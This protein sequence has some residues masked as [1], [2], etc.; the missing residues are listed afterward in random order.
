M[1]ESGPGGS[2]GA[3]W[4]AGRM[5]AIIKIGKPFPGGGTTNLN[6]KETAEMELKEILGKCDHTLLAQGATREEI[7]AICDDGIR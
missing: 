6:I 7:K 2:P 5:S 1:R 4:T 3:Y